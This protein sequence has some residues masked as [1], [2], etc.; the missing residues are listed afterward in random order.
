MTLVT[1]RPDPTEPHPYNHGGNF[2]EIDGQ[3]YESCDDCD[4][5][6]SAEV[7]KGQRGGKK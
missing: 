2:V 3:T 7:H 1:E 6:E 4:Q 5:P